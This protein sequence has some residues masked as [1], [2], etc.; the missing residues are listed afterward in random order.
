VD[1]ALP[2]LVA[3]GQR[4]LHRGDVGGVRA[5]DVNNLIYVP[6]RSAILRLEDTRVLADPEAPPV[7]AAPGAHILTEP[8]PLEIQK[9][10]LEHADGGGPPGVI[11][12]Y[13]CAKFGC[14]EGLIDRLAA[15]A[16]AYPTFVYLAPYPEMDVRIAVTRLGRILVL[17]ELD[18]GRIRRFIE[19]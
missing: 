8:M 16:R 15:V 3:D 12:N 9:Q 4:L 2:E 13:N 6:L 11:I 17:D 14:P 5:A 1:R 19:G 7:E 10:M 18:E